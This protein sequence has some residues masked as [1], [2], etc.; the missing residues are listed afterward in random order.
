M[1]IL[2]QL[3]LLG[4]IFSAGR[5]SI[6]PTEEYFHHAGLDA[7]GKVILYWNFTDDEI[8]FEVRNHNQ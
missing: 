6:S 2:W 5:A 7:E 4:L 3:T 8:T 1:V